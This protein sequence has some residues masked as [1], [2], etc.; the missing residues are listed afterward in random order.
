MTGDTGN[1]PRING[2]GRWLASLTSLWLWLA[3]AAAMAADPAS[4]ADLLTPAER[5]WLAE[6][7][8]IRLAPDPDFPPIEF[9][10]EDGNYQGI[11]ADYAALVER[12][13]GIRFTIVRLQSWD[14]V[15]EKAQRQEID[16]FGA[17]SESPQ[18]ARYMTFTQPHIQLPGVIIVRK[19][20]TGTLQLDDIQQKQVAVVSGYIWQDLLLNDFPDLQLHRV[21][22]LQ[23]GLKETSFGTVDALVANLATASWYI[24]RDGIT[25]LRVAGESGYFGRYAFATRKDWPELNGILEKAL[26][27]VT[28]EEHQQILQRWIAVDAGAPWLSRTGMGI[29]AGALAVL[30]VILAWNRALKSQ[31]RQRTRDLE[32]Q[33][34][35]RQKAE[36]ALDQ[37]NSDLEQRVMERTASL[38]QSN[39]RLRHE[40]AERERVQEDIRR[41]QMTLD[42]TL[43][44]VFMF[45]DRDLRFFYVNQGAVD[46]VGYGIGL[47]LAHPRTSGASGRTGGP[48]FREG[49]LCLLQDPPARQPHW[50]LGFGSEQPAGEPGNSGAACARVCGEIRRQGRPTAA[51]LG[52]LPGK[53]A[54]YRILA[55]PPRP[56]A[57]PTELRT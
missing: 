28:P 55:G 43:D 32:K 16:M 4:T 49:V 40:I 21:P 24:H 27:A 2:K 26:A 36:Q 35:Q 14:E 37:A 33:L 5:A 44:C 42:E 23:T 53:A 11:A 47:L 15:L 50:R 52:R 10:D 56:P 7:P 22:D 46:Q 48:H 30:L 3:S 31:V 38:E 57:R 6:H 12:K 39:Q 45:S 19:D 1:R 25:N 34:E 54:A 41:F 13:L 9:I 51:V 18:R 17:A 20:V 8:V 29:I